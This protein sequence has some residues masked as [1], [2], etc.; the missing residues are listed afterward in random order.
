[1]LM[2]V[3]RRQHPVAAMAA[4]APA[5]IQPCHGTDAARKRVDLQDKQV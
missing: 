1:M 2:Q 4:R 3:S 5:N